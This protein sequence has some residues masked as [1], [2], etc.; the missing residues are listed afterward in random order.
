MTITDQIAGSIIKEQALVI[1]PLAWSEAEKV[2]GLRI[3]DKSRGEVTVES[4]S[5]NETVD[6]LVAQYERLF[7][8]A[9]QAV[10][11]AAAASLIVNLPK[12]EVPISL[13]A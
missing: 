4:G 6:R 3:I 7:G 8:K 12:K 2:K 11:K 9:S 1:G 10:C 5:P 13:L